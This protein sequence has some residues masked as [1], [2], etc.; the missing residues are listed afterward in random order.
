[1]LPHILFKNK[2]INLNF[3][4]D[5]TYE[6]QSRVSFVASRFENGESL[7]CEAANEVTEAVGEEPIRDQVALQ[8]LCEC[9]LHFRNIS[10]GGFF[11]VLNLKL[12]RNLSWGNAC[13][14]HNADICTYEDTVA[15][16]CLFWVI[17]RGSKVGFKSFT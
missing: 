12:R 3:Q 6:T 9:L 13:I 11:R 8:V 10:E 14:G 7:S 1:M 15:L 2:K 17:P 16:S 5:D 4:S